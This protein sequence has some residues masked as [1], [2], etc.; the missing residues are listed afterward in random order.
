MSERGATKADRT[1][2]ASLKNERTDALVTIPNGICLLRIIGS[3][4][5]IW[6]AMIDEPIFF[7]TLYLCLAFSDWLDGKL[8]I[9][10]NQQS[11]IGPKLDTI[12]DVTM[13]VCLL[14]GIV[15]LKWDLLRIEAAWLIAVLVTYLMTVGISIAKFRTLPS[16]HT[17]AAKV[18][19]LLA[20]IAILALFFDWSVWLLRVAAIAVVVT[21][22]ETSLMSL[23]LRR[24][25]TDVATLFHALARDRSNSHESLY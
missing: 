22:L 24:R 7:V 23:L 15:W 19:W 13:Y 2:D 4:F 3:P 11:T 18:S 10:L 21:N 17:R 1:A 16:Y 6:L 8:A 14:V 9:M 20:M 12:S 25:Q 5:L